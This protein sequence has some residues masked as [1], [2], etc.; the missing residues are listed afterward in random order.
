MNTELFALD[1][2]SVTKKISLVV[3]MVLFSLNEVDSVL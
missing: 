2:V 1:F 3:S